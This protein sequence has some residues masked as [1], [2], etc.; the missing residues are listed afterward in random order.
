MAK[1]LSVIAAEFFQDKEYGDSSMAMEAGGHTVVTASTAMTATSKAGPPQPVD[2]LLEDVNAADYDAI[3]FIGGSGCQQYYNDPVAL[4][5]AK[6]FYDANKIT[7]AIC[8]A[9]MILAYA[10]IL[11]G[12]KLT[13]WPGESENLKK[14]GVHCTEE[15]VE[16]DGIVI[17]G[18]G[19]MAASAFGQKVSDAL[20]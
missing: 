13:C 14:H 3:V 2:I 4:D 8:A 1:I 10:G 18:N 5:L 12:K 16:Q 15:P 6:A 19:P 17:T 7:A 11:S 20:Q 9:P